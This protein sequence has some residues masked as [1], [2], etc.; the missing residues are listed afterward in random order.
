[1]PFRTI[2]IG[3]CSGKLQRTECARVDVAL[4]LQYPLD[5]GGIRGNHAHTPARHIMALAHRI[6]F[7]AAFFR[8]FDI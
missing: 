4:Y 1:M 6:E 2:L 7:D 5:K 8:S 3:L